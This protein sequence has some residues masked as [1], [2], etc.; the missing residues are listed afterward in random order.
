[1][2]TPISLSEQQEILLRRAA[3]EMKAANAHQYQIPVH[4]DLASAMCLIGAVQLALRHPKNVGP[5]ATAVR[6]MTDELI[7]RIREDGF[8]ANAEIARLGYDPAHDS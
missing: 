8:E 2:A 4:L 7:E 6:K 5:S 3:A 1:M